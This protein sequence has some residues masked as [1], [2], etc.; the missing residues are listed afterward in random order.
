MILNCNTIKVNIDIKTNKIVNLIQ[1]DFFLKSYSFCYLS[2]NKYFSISDNF[3]I[4]PTL[5]IVY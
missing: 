2:P 4:C 5:V 1:N 3:V